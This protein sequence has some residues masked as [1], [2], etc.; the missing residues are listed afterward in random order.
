MDS[1]END[2]VSNHIPHS[3]LRIPQTSYSRL[4]DVIGSMRDALLAGR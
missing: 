3:A 4:K 2:Y 1:L